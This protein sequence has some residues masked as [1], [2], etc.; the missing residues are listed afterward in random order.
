MDV[1]VTDS[2]LVKP[3]NPTPRSDVGQLL[4]N[5]LS[6]VLVDSYPL[7]GRLV[8][9]LLTNGF[10]KSPLL[11]IQVIK[12]K[13]GG[14]AIGTGI[15]HILSDGT[16]SLHFVNSLCDLARGLKLHLLPL[17]ARNPPRVG[18]SHQEFAPTPTLL[19]QDKDDRK[20]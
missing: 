4:R 6:K 20:Y 13:C 12:F 2:V 16:S 18:F 11:L 1:T 8:E 5:A 14:V 15:Q 9:L 19:H 10:T 7:A 3:V 17:R